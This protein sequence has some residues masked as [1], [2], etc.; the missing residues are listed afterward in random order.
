MTFRG[1]SWHRK[2]KKKK[3]CPRRAERYWW[4]CI[5][6]PL[7]SLR[8][9]VKQYWTKEVGS[10][11]ENTVPRIASRVVPGSIPHCHVRYW[12][13]RFGSKRKSKEKELLRIVPAS[14]TAH[15]CW[16]ICSSIVFYTLILSLFF[17]PS[18]SLA[19][20]TVLA[21]ILYC[22]STLLT[23]AYTNLY[24]CS[25]CLTTTTTVIIITC[26]VGLV[27]VS[28]VFIGRVVYASVRLCVYDCLSMRVSAT[29]SFSIFRLWWTF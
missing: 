10:V 8:S 17:S 15:F 7:L 19:V 25:Y 2:L 11:G 29:F 16:H 5:T 12:A 27:F 23:P 6:Q 22:Y 3:R 9:I 26:C 13:S 4:I 1:T 21:V 28:K 20:W 24:S 14:I 18:T